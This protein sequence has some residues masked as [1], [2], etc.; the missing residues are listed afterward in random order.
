[1]AT[2]KLGSLLLAANTDT[3]LFTA[4]TDQSFNVRFCNQNATIVAVRL[5][6]GPNSGSGPVAEDYLSYDIPVQP[7]GILEDIA[8]VVAAGE[9]VWVRSSAANVSVNAF[10]L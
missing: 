9:K 5:A 8:L 1:M 6:I 7:N 4:A 2:G 10:G 3:L